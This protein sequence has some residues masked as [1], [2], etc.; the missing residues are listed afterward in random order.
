MRIFFLSFLFLFGTL[1]FG[2]KTEGYQ[3]HIN[4]NGKLHYQYT[5]HSSRK[6][7]LDD[8]FKLFAESKKEWILKDEDCV[9][10]A[11]RTKK[12]FEV[13]GDGKDQE[14]SCE[15]ASLFIDLWYEYAH[16]NSQ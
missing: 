11:R 16:V 12:G 5:V 4:Q 2:Q 15:A 8:F 1:S 9:A 10:I 13:I 3:Y 7:I 14:F 6:V